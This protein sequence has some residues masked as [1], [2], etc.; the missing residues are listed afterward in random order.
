MSEISPDGLT[1]S[2]FIASRQRP[3]SKIGLTMPIQGFGAGGFT[4]W[5]PS[6]KIESTIAWQ[7]GVP[8]RQTVDG[9][10]GDPRIVALRDQA[11]LSMRVA[12]PRRVRVD[13]SFIQYTAEI[14]KLQYNLS[15]SDL[16][17]L[18]KGTGW[19]RAMIAHILGGDDV[20]RALAT[21]DAAAAEVLAPGHAIPQ[22]D[23]RP[24]V[25]RPNFWRRVL[26]RF[27]RR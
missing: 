10:M 16:Q 3:D 25:P 24:V 15:D 5:V 18:L 21:I 7:D 8:V 23:A 19:H 6:P 13:F 12:G 27:N 22:P 11:I 26:R 14:L 1:A 2:Q 20:V 17:F 4:L 9:C